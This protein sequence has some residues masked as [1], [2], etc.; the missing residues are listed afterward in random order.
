MSRPD[1][2]ETLTR[3]R[4][5]ERLPPVRGRLTPDAPLAGL[6]W[7]RVGGPAEVLF[8]PADLQDLQDF[9]RGCPPDVQVLPIGVASN[10]L[11]RD[12]GVP[13]VVVRLGAAF[14]GVTVEGNRIHAGAAALDGSVA[15]AA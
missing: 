10:L 6:T 1:D 5:L 4:L 3:A 7:F 12:G 9:L 2:T 13:G 11:V 8:K 15:L 14:A